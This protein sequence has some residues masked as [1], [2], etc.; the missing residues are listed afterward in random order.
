MREDE[1]RRH[2]TA[3]EPGQPVEI[4]WRRRRVGHDGQQRIGHRRTGSRGDLLRLRIPHVFAKQLASQGSDD[5]LR[6]RIGLRED[7]RH[8]LPIEREQRG[9]HRVFV[10]AGIGPLHLLDLRIELC[11][12]RPQRTHG[13]VET[14]QRARRFRITRL[15]RRALAT[16]AEHLAELV[17]ELAGVVIRG[18]GRRG[19]RRHEGD[20]RV[21]EVGQ[22]GD[23]IVPGSA[24]AEQ[25]ERGRRSFTGRRRLQRGHSL[26][27]TGWRAA[28]ASSL[29]CAFHLFRLP[30][31]GRG[32]M[33]VRR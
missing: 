3:I 4:V 9:A 15:N 24:I 7:G 16:T 6:S 26:A 5:V 33:A 13:D 30:K 22:A 28:R 12:R 19:Q 27:G 21:Y 1:R 29:H 10:A 25:E 18:I 11:T 23:V 20:G 31:R 8:G 17:R 14:Q 2:L 32:S